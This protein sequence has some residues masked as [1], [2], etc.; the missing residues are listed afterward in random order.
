M[1]WVTFIIMDTLHLCPSQKWNLLLLKPSSLLILLIYVIW[2]PFFGFFQ[3]TNGF[4]KPEV[5]YISLFVTVMTRIITVTQKGCN[6][7]LQRLPI[8][9]LVQRNERKIKWLEVS[10]PYSLQPPRFPCIRLGRASR[11]PFKHIESSFIFLSSIGSLCL[12]YF[13]LDDIGFPYSS[14]EDTVT[15]W[16]SDFHISPIEDIK[17]LLSKYSEVSII[18]KSLSSHCHITKTCAKDLAVIGGYQSSHLRKFPFI[19]F[20]LCLCLS[21][22]LL[23]ISYAPRF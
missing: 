22:I 19:H 3:F 20:P 6:S 8:C 4:Q 2:S 15:L 1:E 21:L 14:D 17:D 5:S 11:R 12:F 13:F 18:D 9:D 10:Y 16:S 7:N 23:D